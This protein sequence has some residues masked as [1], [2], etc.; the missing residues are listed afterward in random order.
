MCSTPAVAS[1]R[2]W[3]PLHFG[4]RRVVLPPRLGL[5]SALCV[6]SSPSH[7]APAS[8]FRRTPLVAAGCFDASIRHTLVAR[9]PPVCSASL[10]TTRAT[11][12]NLVVAALPV[13]PAGP[14]NT[15][16]PST[17]WCPITPVARRRTARRCAAATN[18]STIPGGVD[19]GRHHR[20]VGHA[21][22]LEL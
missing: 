1:R 14:M 21:H 2:P 22:H 4:S 16:H 20:L 19:C 10:P 17:V 6:A 9:S 18:G 5:T 8:E 15:V 13:T 11:T 12:F 3:E 7:A